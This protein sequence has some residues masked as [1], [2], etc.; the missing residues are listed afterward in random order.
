MELGFHTFQ[1]GK[2]Y[3]Y[4]VINGNPVFLR[5]IVF[6]TNADKIVLVHEWGV[7]TN[8]DSW[9]PPKGQ[10]EWAEFA[11]EGVR[12]HSKYS[13][14]MILNCMKKAMIREMVEEA[15]VMPHEIK[16]LK[17]MPLYYMQKWPE[18]EVKNAHFLYQYWQAE[19]PSLDNA[20]R[21]MKTL[22]EN[23]DWKYILPSDVTEKDKVNWWSPKEGWDCIREG[24]SKKMMRLYYE[25]LNARKVTENGV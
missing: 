24:F 22:L 13:K 10:M 3:A 15:K 23:Q 14:S 16:H 4:A 18:C 8:K 6:L 21:R 12:N 19:L 1:S 7:P 17:V 5:N 2:Q 11:N 20:Q 9:E 25:F